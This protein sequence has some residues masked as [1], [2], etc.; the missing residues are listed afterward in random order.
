V[1][2]GNSGTTQLAFTVT[3]S[4]AADS[5]V[6]VSY[7]TANGSATAG[8]D[9]AATSGILSFAAGETTKQIVVNVVGDTAYEGNETLSVTLSVPSVNARIVTSSA[10][11]TITN[12]DPQPPPPS[13]PTLAISSVSA[14]EN[15]GSFV[16]TVTLSAASAS[17]VTVR[18]A[19]V[20][21]TAKS[22]RTGDFTATSGT[23]TFNPGQTTKAISVA[24]RNDTLVEPDETFFVDLSRASGAT[25]AVGRGT[26]TIRNDDGLTAAAFASLAAADSASQSPK[27]R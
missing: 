23:L 24:V 5:T 18:Y 8:S 4:A 13:V 11:G 7:A 12:D 1:A 22:G 25:I 14:L 6:T 19:T 17:Q 21:G 10:Q 3:L 27:R 16:F 26:G 2:E 9:Y 15:G 20:N